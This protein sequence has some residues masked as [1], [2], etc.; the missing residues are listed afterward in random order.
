MQRTDSYSSSATQMKTETAMLNCV[1]VALLHFNVAFLSINTVL[2][3]LQFLKVQIVGLCRLCVYVCV[4]GEEAVYSFGIECGRGRGALW[5]SH[6]W[7]F[8]FYKFWKE[9]LLDLET[10]KTNKQKKHL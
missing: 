5:K 9:Y 10:L 3:V 7:F 1:L 2:E 6:L 4:K 8:L